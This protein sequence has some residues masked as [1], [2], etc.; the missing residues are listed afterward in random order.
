M[1]CGQIPNNTS[2]THVNL[3]LSILILTGQDLLYR[4]SFFFHTALIAFPSLEDGKAINAVA[5]GKLGDLLSILILPSCMEAR[6]E[7]RKEYNGI[8]AFYT[9]STRIVC[10]Q[11]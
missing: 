6:P 3:C 9:H 8:F 11:W 2:T 5:R 10:V 1:L 7:R 4:F